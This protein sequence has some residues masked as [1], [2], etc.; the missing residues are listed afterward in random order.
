MSDLIAKLFDVGCNVR[1][2]SQPF[3]RQLKIQQTVRP[4]T[5]SFKQAQCPP[6]F[7]KSS[8]RRSGLSRNFGSR[9]SRRAF[10][11]FLIFGFGLNLADERAA[12][13]E[14]AQLSAV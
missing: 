8:G 6:L 14:P 12:C 13:I 2:G 4:A 1:H 7:R 3:Y 9:F 11:A 5:F 10:A